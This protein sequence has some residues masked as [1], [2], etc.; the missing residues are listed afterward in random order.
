MTNKSKQ[1][2]VIANWKM[3]LGLQESIDLAAQYAK[4]IKQDAVTVVACTSEIALTAVGEKFKNSDIKLGAQNVFWESKGAYTGEISAE[5]LAEAGCS[6]VIVGHSERRQY[7]LENYQMIHQKVKAVLSQDNLIPII[8]IGETLRDREEDKAD[9]VITDQLQ[10][11]LGGVRM[12]PQQK[13]I[14]AYEPIW[15]IGTGQSIKPADAQTMHE[16][17]YA[18]LVD[19]FGIDIVKNQI[20]VIYGG[21]VNNKNING[22]VKLDNVDGFLVGTA[23]LQ[24]DEF[25][26]IINTFAHSK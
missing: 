20:Q 2:I 22:F 21:S 14:I 23:S 8:C 7:L 24:T 6:Y 9:Y 10:Q 26:N 11:A 13:I 25:S 3:R 1:K 16:I 19:I 12:L 15:A 5:I 17:I 4:K 18:S